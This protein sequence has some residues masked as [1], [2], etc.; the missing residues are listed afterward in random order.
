MMKKVV[1]ILLIAILYLSVSS[2]AKPTEQPKTETNSTNQA[3]TGLYLNPEY[4]LKSKIGEGVPPPDINTSVFSP[5][6]SV[7]THIFLP[8]NFTSCPIGLSSDFSL[9]FF[10]LW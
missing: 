3:A 7:N 6:P 1:S 4:T 5:F 10:I 8:S 2:C 9:S